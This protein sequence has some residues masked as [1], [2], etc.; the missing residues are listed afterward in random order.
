MFHI[1]LDRTVRIQRTNVRRLWRE[2]SLRIR[3]DNRHRLFHVHDEHELYAEQR[4][5][6][7]SVRFEEDDAVVH[8]DQHSLHLK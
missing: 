8:V 7:D 6:T 1:D 3:N 2:N 4:H 5:R